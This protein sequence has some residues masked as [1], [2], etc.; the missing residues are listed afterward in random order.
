MVTYTKPQQ[1]KKEE[2]RRWKSSEKSLSSSFYLN[3]TRYAVWRCLTFF[4]HSG[5]PRRTWPYY[6][7]SKNHQ[8]A[9]IFWPSLAAKIHASEYHFRDTLQRRR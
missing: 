7:K 4:R 1:R 5:M 6:V 2:N 3:L 9:M 8:T